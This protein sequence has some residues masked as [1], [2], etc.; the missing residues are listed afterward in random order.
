[1]MNLAVILAPCELAH[2]PEH[3]VVLYN[4]HVSIWGALQFVLG[5]VYCYHFAPRR[6]S[7]E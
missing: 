4:L 7:I 5:A 3:P 2:P 1:M 6:A